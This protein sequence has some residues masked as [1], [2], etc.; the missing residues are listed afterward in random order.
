MFTKMKSVSNG[1]IWRG[2][3]G[4]NCI[5][6]CKESEPKHLECKC[7]ASFFSL[8]DKTTDIARCDAHSDNTQKFIEK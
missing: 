6:R 4:E 8:T 7:D 5:L 1:I 2:N 3:L